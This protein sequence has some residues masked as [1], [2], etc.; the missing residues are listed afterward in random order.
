LNRETLLILFHLR[1]RLAGDLLGI[2][3]CLRY[4][5]SLGRG[6]NTHE[7]HDSKRDESTHSSPEESLDEVR[8]KSLAETLGHP[9]V[10]LPNIVI[11]KRNS[12]LA[13]SSSP[14]WRPSRTG[15]HGYAVTSHSSQSLTES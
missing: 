1:A 7:Y 13:I 12:V 10:H 4:G 5:Q 8:I 6:R 9:F 15:G 2:C 3:D 14:P 11:W